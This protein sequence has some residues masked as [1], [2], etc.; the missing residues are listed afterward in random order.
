MTPF[1]LYRGAASA[2][3]SAGKGGAGSGTE[4]RNFGVQ[5]M[6][7]QTAANGPARER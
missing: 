7:G 1:L 2:E 5:H 6:A 3:V 4:G